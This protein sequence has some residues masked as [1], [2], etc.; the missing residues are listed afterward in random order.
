MQLKTSL[1]HIERY[2]AKLW[3]LH[4]KENKNEIS[5]SFN[6]YDYLKVIQYADES[7]R[8]T[9]IATKLEVSKPSA[10]AMIVRLE[11]RGLIAR[12]ACPE[13]ARVNHVVLTDKAKV[14]LDHDDAIY[15]N[16]SDEI[17]G[18]LSPQEY[19]QLESLLAKLFTK[20]TI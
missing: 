11:K 14:E 3:R 17:A 20:L 16:F 18:A 10:S 7:M 5:L 12:L 19:Q 2:S 13:D 9:D 1:E 15:A 6:E 4:C 8:L